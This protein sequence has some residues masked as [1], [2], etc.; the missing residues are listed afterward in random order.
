MTAAECLE[1]DSADEEFDGRVSL[2]EPSG[3]G[4]EK[5]QRFGADD[6]SDDA[7]SDADDDWAFDLDDYGQRLNTLT[8]S[9]GVSN[10]GALQPNTNTT[11]RAAAQISSAVRTDILLSEKKADAPRNLGLTRDTRAT[12]EQVLD[13]RTL[14]ILGKMEKRGVFSQIFKT[15][16]TGKEA[17]VYYATGHKPTALL[18]NMGEYL[19]EGAELAVKVYKTSILVFK[20]R[21]RYVE[22]EFRFR[23]GYCKSNPRKMVAMWAEKEMRN[24]RR[25]RNANLPC[26]IPVEVRQNVLVMEYVGQDGVAAPRL[27]DAE[28]SSDAW[29]GLYRMLIRIVRCMFQVCRLVHG[30]LSEYNILHY[31]DALYVIDVSQ[32]VEHD[33]P[34]ALEFLKRDLVNVNDFFGRMSVPVVPVRKLFDFILAEAPR[35]AGAPVD[36]ANA[37][38]PTEETELDELL[39]DA[40]IAALYDGEQTNEEEI[41]E[42]VFLNSWTVS[43]FNQVSDIAEIEKDLKQ[44][45]VGEDNLYDRL[46]G[47]TRGVPGSETEESGDEDDSEVNEPRPPTNESCGD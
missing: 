38:S 45:E 15:I 39:Q 18:G 42:Q 32:S 11:A 3:K 40:K 29:A 8:A 4:E 5:K 21:A 6:W 27:K 16:S 28:V 23:R 34:Q 10:N 20:D 43:Y 14:L 17:N 44:R 7:W 36:P 30:D 37:L 33:H 24:L 19:P 1:I 26:P 22:G 47:D 41:A 31:R 2:P 13:P 9:H 12:V 46:V 25:M 35:S